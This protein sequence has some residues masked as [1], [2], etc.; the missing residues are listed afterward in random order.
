MLVLLTLMPPSPLQKRMLLRWVGVVWVQ[1]CL[2][3]PAEETLLGMISKQTRLVEPRGH[4]KTRLLLSSAASRPRSAPQN[5]TVI[6]M[7]LFS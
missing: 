2:T 7:R 3:S 4:E 6:Y 1:L 5:Q